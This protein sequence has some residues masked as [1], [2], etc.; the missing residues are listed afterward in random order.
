[1]NEDN[2]Q[3]ELKE[4][5]NNLEDKNSN[6][7]VQM[8][9]KQILLNKYF[10]FTGRINRK[11]FI[12]NSLYLLVITVLAYFFFTVFIAGIFGSNKITSLVLSAVLIALT[13]VSL[14]ANVSLSARRFYDLG[15]DARWLFLVFGFNF[16]LSPRLYGSEIAKYM[17]AAVGLV[18]SLFL[19]YLFCF[20]KGTPG[21]SKY[22]EDPLASEK[23]PNFTKIEKKLVLVFLAIN[24]ILLGIVKFVFN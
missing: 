4:K 8:S 11:T 3:K 14:Y 5:E 19:L 6:E 9:N 15:I 16:L 17:I 1:M 21:T 7:F 18:Y 24:I 2:S 23:K 13:F 10:S 22:G 20:K 12:I